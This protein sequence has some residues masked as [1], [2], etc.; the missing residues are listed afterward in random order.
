MTQPSSVATVH[1]GRTF[2]RVHQPDPRNWPVADRLT[3]MEIS[4]LRS[5][6][7]RVGIWLDQGQLGACVGFGISGELAA[8][9]IPQQH[10]TNQWATEL[11]FQAQRHDGQPGGE[12]PGADPQRQ[13]SSVLAGM[14]AATALGAYDGYHWAHSEPELALAVGHLGPAVLG[15]S[16]HADMMTPDAEDYVHA[17]G[18]T[19]GGHCILCSGFDAHE[20][21]YVL[22]N[23]W[24]ESWGVNGEAKISRDDMA[25]LLA[26]S[27]EAAIPLG[28]NYITIA[29]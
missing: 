6:I 15:V 13:G 22:H 21:F 12:W 25:L 17:T 8:I 1:G 28:R 24:G 26:D 20:G 27:G 4:I 23:S 19:V 5:N 18:D 3:A 16:W 9:P 10:V 29:A 7:W 14:R 2:D 11:Y